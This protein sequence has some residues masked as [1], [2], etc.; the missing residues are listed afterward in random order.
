MTRQESLK[1]RIRARM[2]KT[3]ERYTT[4]R[5]MLLD[6]GKRGTRT[7]LS[8]P[9]TSEEAVRETTGRGWDEWC[10]V[11]DAWP[12]KA[13]G[14]AAIAQYLVDE[15]GVDGWW[16]QTVTVGYERITGLRL[17]YQR[18]DGTFT[19]TKSKTIT[20]DPDLIRKMLL[21]PDGRTDLFPGEETQLR[22]KPEAKSLRIAIGRGV[23]LFALEAKDQARC[24]IT[25]AHEKLPT[26]EDVERWRF[27]WEE[28]L[29]ALDDG[30]AER[31]P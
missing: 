20:A 29:T 12:G 23:A 9:E 24:K 13:D 10:D 17:P 22:S 8:P 21:D 19:A 5:T 11:I 4:A 16:A 25:V 18:S 3:G 7:W 30:Q 15:H 14:H 26:F 27:Y 28:W 1:R 6:D 2:E 31:H